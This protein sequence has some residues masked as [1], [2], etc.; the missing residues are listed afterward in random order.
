MKLSHRVTLL[1]LLWVA[2]AG[3]L[4]AVEVGHVDDFEDARAGWSGDTPGLVT[5]GG[6]AGEGDG[7]LRL[8]SRGGGGAGSRLATYNPTAVWTGDFGAAGVTA[9]ELDFKNDATSSGPLEMRLVLFGP[10][11]T[12]DRWTS[13][14]A[15]TVPNNG[16]WERLSFPVDAE[17]L[18]R[19]GGTRTYDEMIAKVLR[20][21]VRHDNGDPSRDG[22]PVVASAGMDN[23]TILG[24]VLDN[25]DFNDDGVVD[26]QD[27]DLLL[28]EVRLGMN[29]PRFDRTQDGLVNDQDILHVVTLPEELNTYIGD[30]NLD[31]EFN[32]SDLVT[33]LSAGQYEDA[34]PVNSTWASGDWN[35]DGEFDTSDL[36]FALAE[37]GYEAGPRG[38]V[39]V[40][41]VPE[42]AS[43]MLLLLGTVI[44]LSRRVLAK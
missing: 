37:G 35:G 30:A 26:V 9:I 38:A 24:G 27:I 15:I 28:V 23:V 17:S 19:V 42:P 2:Q 40:A 34:L 11:S 39:A 44:W 12:N 16:Q 20:V 43:A 41:A 13:T 22:A 10:N 4:S 36:V 3:P 29:P 33:V 31:G 21:Q 5:T 18:T 7:Y 8:V 14:E 25:S 32:S 1:S 6:P